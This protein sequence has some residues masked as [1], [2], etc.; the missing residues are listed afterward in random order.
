MALR[1]WKHERKKKEKGKKEKRYFNS[2]GK[3]PL[4]QFI[5]GSGKFS[6][7]ARLYG[8]ARCFSKRWALNVSQGLEF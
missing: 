8:K 6:T 2:E 5:E 3:F 7:A 1:H 4:E